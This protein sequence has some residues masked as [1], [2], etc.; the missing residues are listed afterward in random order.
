[1]LPLTVHLLYTAHVLLVWAR[2]AVRAKSVC[3]VSSSH[4]QLTRVCLVLC[5]LCVAVSLAP[6]G[7]PAMSL[8]PDPAKPCYCS[9]Q[10]DCLTNKGT[11]KSRDD[12]RD[13]GDAA[14][15]WLLLSGR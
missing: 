4:K 12:N 13:D 7:I 3:K 6:T 5:V 14:V 1:M 11:D 9:A 8:A 15:V 2:G 10:Q